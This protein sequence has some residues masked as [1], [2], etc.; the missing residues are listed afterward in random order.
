MV[1][2]SPRF[3]NLLKEIMLANQEFLPDSFRGI[4]FSTNTPY[5]F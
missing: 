4:R 3:E 1:N 2:F 5:L